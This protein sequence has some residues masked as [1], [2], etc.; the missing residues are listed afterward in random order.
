[1]GDLAQTDASVTSSAQRR[2]DPGQADALSY[3]RYGPALR[4]LIDNNAACAR[5]AAAVSTSR[6]NVDCPST[7]PQDAVVMSTLEH[8]AA[9]LEHLHNRLQ[10]IASP[11]IK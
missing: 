8:T 10:R 6:H 11:R 3:G 5:E 2:V 1:M 9:R 7:S 4:N